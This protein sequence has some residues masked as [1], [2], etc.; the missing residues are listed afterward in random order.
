MAVRKPDWTTAAVRPELLFHYSEDPGIEAFVPHVPASNP[1]SEPSV[2]AIEARYAPLYWFPRD[3]PRAAVWANDPDQLRDLRARFDTPAERV[4]F[5]FGRDEQWIHAT[6]LYE[7]SFAATPFAPWPDAEGQWIASTAVR[8]AERRTM[9]DLVVT[10]VGAGVDLRF[11]DDLASVRDE[12]VG[13]GLPFS[14]VRL[15]AG[16]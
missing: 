16:L 6:Q 5:A 4:H 11:I 3:C 8:P 7:Y 14:I 9:T 15:A 13:S 12:I 1:A 10:Q 2:W